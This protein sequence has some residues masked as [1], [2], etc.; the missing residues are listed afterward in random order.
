[1]ES[2]PDDYEPCGDCGFDH[3]YEQ[4]AAVK[5]HGMKVRSLHTNKHDTFKAYIQFCQRE[6][7]PSNKCR[8]RTTS[9]R[10]S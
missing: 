10:S 6:P 8:N 4:D 5:A 3:G 2:T 7:L 9:T 1:M